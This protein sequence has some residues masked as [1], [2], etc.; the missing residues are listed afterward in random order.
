MTSKP[1]RVTHVTT[2]PMSLIFMKGQTRFMRERG[3]ELRFVSSPGKGLEAFGREEDAP[4]HA[5]RMERRVTP[6]RDLLSLLELWYHFRRTQPDIV[7]AHTPKGGLLATLA[8]RLAGVPERIY[9]V[10]GLPLVGASGPLRRL[11]TLTERISC[12]NATRVWSVSSS[13]RDDLVSH[14][15]CPLARVEILGQ[16]SGQ[17]VDL[18]HFDLSRHEDAGRRVRLE[19]G[20]EAGAPVF[21]FVGRLVT[22]KG[23]A[24]LADAW[25]VISTESTSAHLL[26][27]GSYEEGR[28]AV[29]AHVRRKLR[30]LPRVHLVGHVYDTGPYYA[31]MD[32]VL[33]PTYREGF[34]NVLLE[35]GAM[36]RPVVATEVTGCVDAVAHEQTGLLVPPGDW[37]ELASAIG[38]YLAS[39][40]MR[41]AHGDAAR[42]RVAAHFDRKAIWN[43][44]LVGYRRTEEAESPSPVA[45][46]S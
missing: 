45:S 5:V 40:P 37:R 7:H 30:E 43:H 29:P 10:R 1:L 17:G 15:I 42:A 28:D 22:Q 3:V 46:A 31:A 20:L 13:L 24:E 6:L 2:V 35:A 14:E 16:G 32:V 25:E 27:V 19:L 38:R 8:A 34:P 18:D 4:V 44:I 12:N 9:H 39:E 26:L 23:I 33:L 41:L 11:L 36:K 21:G